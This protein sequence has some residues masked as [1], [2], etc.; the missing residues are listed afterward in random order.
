MFLL[1]PERRGKK[2]ASRYHFS[3]FTFSTF[4]IDVAMRGKMLMWESLKLEAE[5]RREIVNICSSFP[6]VNSSC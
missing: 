1:V 4:A 6:F 5:L 3:S 2:D